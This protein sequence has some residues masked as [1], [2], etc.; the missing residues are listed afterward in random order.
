MDKPE[1]SPPT[2]SSSQ[3]LQQQPKGSHA[4]QSRETITLKGAALSRLAGHYHRPDFSQ[5]MAQAVIEDMLQDLAEFSTADVERAC[6][7]WRTSTERFFPTSG[8]LINLIRPPSEFDRPSAPRSRLPVFK[9]YPEPER[10]THK[11][12]AEILRENGHGA[13]ADGYEAWKER[14]KK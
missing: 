12:V 6:M 14:R 2:T 10:K 1:S 5:Q 4:L 11:S 7:Q 8:Q 3:A 13:A 9:G